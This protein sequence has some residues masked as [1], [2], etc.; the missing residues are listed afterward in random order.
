MFVYYDI[1]NRRQDLTSSIIPS[2]SLQK[3]IRFYFL[4]EVPMNLNILN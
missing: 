3:S 4:E 2:D 1:V